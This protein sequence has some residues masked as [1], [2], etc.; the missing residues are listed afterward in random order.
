MFTRSQFC[1][2]F[3]ATP[4]L[5]AV[6]GWPA[7]SIADDAVQKVTAKLVEI[8]SKFPPDDLYDYAYVMRYEVI[9]GPLD[10][11]SILVAHYKPR[12]PRSKIKDKM[13]S[14]VSGKVRSFA[15]GDVHKLELSGDLKKIWKGALV[16][17][18]A[19]TDRKSVRYW[20]LVADPA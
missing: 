13:K 12:Q 2:A 5:V 19:A 4:I 17:E 3:F 7:A 14:F 15:V 1:R 9:G 10:R 16:D 20:C 11:S 18:F 6:L 8:P